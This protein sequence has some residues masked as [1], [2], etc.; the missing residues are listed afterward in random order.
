MLERNASGNF[1]P[2]VCRALQEHPAYIE[3]L[4]ADLLAGHF[5]S[6]LYEDI[7]ASVGLQL[8]GEIPEGREEKRSA[9]DPEFR[10]KILTAY[11]YR[12]AVTGW[13]LRVGHGLAGLEVA[14]IFW[15][16]AGGPSTERNGIALNALHHNLFDLGVFTLT[17][18]GVT[19]RPSLFG[20]SEFFRVSSERCSGRV[21]RSGCVRGCLA[22]ARGGTLCAA[23]L[24]IPLSQCDL[25]LAGDHD[26]NAGGACPTGDDRGESAQRKPPVLE[27]AA[28]S[29]EGA[30]SYPGHDEGAWCWRSGSGLR[31]FSCRSGES[32]VWRHRPHHSCL[33]M[34]RSPVCVPECLDEVAFRL[35]GFNLWGSLLPSSQR[36]LLPARLIPQCPRRETCPPQTGSVAQG[37][38][39]SQYRLC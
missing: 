35:L 11:E 29:S 17:G 28:H 20:F 23:S 10:T 36:C 4:A 18:E 30:V 39:P 1:A 27:V 2:D 37:R 8:E 33:P 26:K 5:P 24:E 22:P 31:L 32:G 15:H 12:C 14:H 6:S 9:R 3:A 34:L 25:R 21:S 16:V 38:R 13:D 7:C 19:Q